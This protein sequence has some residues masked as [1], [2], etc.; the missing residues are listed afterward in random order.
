[1]I[2]KAL[3]SLFDV[4]RNEAATNAAF[5]R[6]LEDSLLKFAEELTAQRR[7]EAVV[8]EFHPHIEYKRVSAEAFRE[9][10]QKFDLRELRLII[11]NHGLDPSRALQGA[12]VS[13]KRLVEAIEAAS[14]KRAERDAKLF[15]Y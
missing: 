5:A 1:M 14:A 8:G 11:A 9:R 3:E 12:R 13:K 2:E 4:V 10:L 15:Q 7:A 6:K